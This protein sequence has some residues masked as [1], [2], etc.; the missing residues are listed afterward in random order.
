MEEGDV[1]LHDAIKMRFAL[2]KSPVLYT[3]GFFAPKNKGGIFMQST[4]STSTRKITTLAM[5]SALAF[6]MV[7][8]SKL[9]PPMVL[10][11]H[12]D[13]K[14]I[15]IVIAG[16]L[17]GPL[18]ALAMIVVVSTLEMFT[19]SQTGPIGLVMNIIASSA[20]ACTASFIYMKNRTIRGAICGLVAGSILATIV[21]IAWNYLL[22][23][24]FMAIPRAEVVPLLMTAI[25]PFNVIK[26]C[27]N[28]ALAILLY[29]Y[30]KAALQ[31]TKMVPPSL[32]S[33]RENN[34]GIMVVAFFVIVTCVLWVLA[35]Q[36]VI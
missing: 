21:M 36:G 8:V 3:W 33:K 26:N 32:D 4:Q 27:L 11:L 5:L 2:V 29:K 15:I 13:P 23:P 16:F 25:L 9:F 1:L 20:F 19:V 14:D 31:A 18:A 24:V 10:F 22:T 35:I 17:F 34:G 28:A 6:V 12:Y 30:V 7:A